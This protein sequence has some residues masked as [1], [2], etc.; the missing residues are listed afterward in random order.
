MGKEIYPINRSHFMKLRKFARKLLI[1]CISSKIEPILYGSYLLLYYTND[2]TIKVNDIDFFIKEK[3]FTK[4]IEVLEENK[5]KFKFSK[6]HHTC[7]VIN[8][9]LKVEFDSIDFWYDGPKGFTDINFDGITIKTISLDAL[10]GIYKKASETSKD[11]PESN[12]R[13]YRLIEK[14]NNNP[15]I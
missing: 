11:K 13:K 2:K 8:G 5:I 9:K 7:Q 12:L 3:E 10:K 4:L 15:N 14:F 6:K 1:Y